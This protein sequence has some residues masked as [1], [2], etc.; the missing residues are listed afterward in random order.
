MAGR[1]A[2]A[3]IPVK[4]PSAPALRAASRIVQQTRA[5]LPRPSPTCS[6]GPHIGGLCERRIPRESGP[7]SRVPSFAA[8]RAATNPCFVAECSGGR[9]R[10]QCSPIPRGQ[11]SPRWCCLGP[12]RFSCELRLGSGAL[13]WA[14][15]PLEQRADAAQGAFSCSYAVRQSGW[16]CLA[17]PESVAPAPTSPPHMYPSHISPT[18]A[19]R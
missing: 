9:A 19:L 12:L 3:P 1:H 4:G 16:L 5:R 10:G 6:R 2:A 18:A 14:L 13:G 11:G 15:R 8:S 17:V 7:Q